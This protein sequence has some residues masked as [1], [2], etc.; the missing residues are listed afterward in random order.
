[1]SVMVMR[2]AR[3]KNSR[4]R[5]ARSKTELERARGK[6]FS[7]ARQRQPNTARPAR[8]VFGDRAMESNARGRGRKRKVKMTDDDVKAIRTYGE[9]SLQSRHDIRTPR[10]QRFAYAL[11]RRSA[12]KWWKPPSTPLRASMRRCLEGRIGGGR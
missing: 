12:R 5:K 9:G 6:A 11:S 8:S 3:F 1:M 10:P 7:S 2:K 4:L